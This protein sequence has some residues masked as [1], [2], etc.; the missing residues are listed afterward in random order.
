MTQHREEQAHGTLSSDHQRWQA[1]CDRDS[2]QDGLFVFAVLTTGIYCRPSC[3]SHR[4]RRENVSFY[5]T[6]DEAEKA[7]YRACK[8]CQPDQEAIQTPHSQAIIQACRKIQLSEEEPNL[9]ALA[10]SAGLSPSYFQRLFKAQVGLSPKRFAMAVRK[11]RLREELVQATT[12][13]SAIYDAG[14]ASASRAYADKKALGLPPS[15]RLQGADGEI[16]H[17]A[18][19]ETNLGPIVMGATERGVCF[20]EF[21]EPKKEI[22]ALEAR[23]PRAQLQPAQDELAGWLAIVIAR[24]ESPYEASCQTNSNTHSVPLDIRGT[25]FQEKVW[26]SLT[27]IP[28]GETVS[29]AQLAKTL[30]KPKAAR[31]VASACSANHLAVLVPCHRVVRGS[32]ELAGYKWGIERKRKLLKREKGTD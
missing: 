8:R 3:S 16:I 20:V 14:Y 11:N 13:T 19:A 21:V 2:D 18:I 1:V 12:V 31:A 10:Q 6:P 5:K 26:E 28:L 22:M 30:G 9:G 7:G 27:K 17:Y 4:A 29:Y 32:G 25:V 24:I 15:R 23:F